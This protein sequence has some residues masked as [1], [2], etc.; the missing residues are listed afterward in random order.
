[1]RRDIDLRNSPSVGSRRLISAIGQGMDIPISR[2]RKS[3]DTSVIIRGKIQW[4]FYDNNGGETER[5]ALDAKGDL[6]ML[7]FER[8]R[9]HSLVCLEV[10]ACC[11]R[12]SMGG[13]KAFGEG[14]GYFGVVRISI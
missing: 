8:G 7:N 1:M 4:V 11:L 13:Y 5:V 12:V 9:L 14:G 3:S 2:H 6:R 10:G